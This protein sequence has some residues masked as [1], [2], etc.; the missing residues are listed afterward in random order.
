MSVLHIHIW[1]R[2][3]PGEFC[4]GVGLLKLFLFAA[5]DLRRLFSV[6]LF[7]VF[8]REVLV[9]PKDLVAVGPL[10]RK[11]NAALEPVSSA[12]DVLIEELGQDSF[13]SAQDS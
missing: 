10:G 7:Q 2:L 3:P 6:L 11:N 5:D 4:V 1:V 8:E 13:V 9:I 12:R